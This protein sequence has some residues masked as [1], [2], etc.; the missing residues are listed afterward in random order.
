M[1]TAPCRSRASSIPAHIAP[2][3]CPALRVQYKGLSARELCMALVALNRGRRAADARAGAVT[4]L[5]AQTLPED[6]LKS[7]S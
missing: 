1:I 6:A 5:P 2:C 7:P 3:A 4:E